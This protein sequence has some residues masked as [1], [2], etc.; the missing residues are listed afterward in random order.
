M[1]QPVPLSESRGPP[2]SC[3]DASE[4]DASRLADRVSDGR[5]PEGLIR[6]LEPREIIPLLLIVYGIT[7]LLALLA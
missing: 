1:V 7:I 4:K 3:R 6:I 5:E 2:V